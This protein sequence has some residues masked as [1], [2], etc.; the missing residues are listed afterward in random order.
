MLI[1]KLK[2]DVYSYLF[3]LMFLNKSATFFLKKKNPCWKSITSCKFF[4]KFFRLFERWA[5]KVK[6]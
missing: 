2:V 4:R 1:L 3:D 6:I 5:A